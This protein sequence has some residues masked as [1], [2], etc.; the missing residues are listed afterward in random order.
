MQQFGCC[1]D[2]F[3]SEGKQ[4]SLVF[5][6]FCSQKQHLEKFSQDHAR[7]EQVTKLFQH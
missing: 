6:H 7:L 1:N 4:K 3:Q 5:Y 2:I